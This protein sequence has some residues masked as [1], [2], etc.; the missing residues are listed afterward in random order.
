MRLRTFTTSRKRLL[1]AAAVAASLT[2]TSLPAAASP[3]PAHTAATRTVTAQAQPA[4]RPVDQDAAYFVSVAE[5]TARLAAGKVDSADLIAQIQALSHSQNLS[6]A[7]VRILIAQLREATGTVAQ[8]VTAYNADQAAKAAARKAAAEKA[9]RAAAAARA[10]QAAAAA[11]AQAQ[12]A[13]QNSPRQAP[14]PAPASVGTPVI[15]SGGSPQAIAQQMMSSR[16]GW[17]SDQFQCLDALWNRESGWRVNA[18]N[19]SGAYGIPQ[20]LPGSKMGPGWQ[21]NA[22]VQ[23]AWGLGYIQSRYGTPCG[24]WAHSQSTGWY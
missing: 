10:A 11:K 23:I 1:I 6:P 3:G 13:R 20:A 4:Q 17:G 5:S 7:V 15:V 9:A 24:A 19:S 2:F 18:A 22:A 16:Y 8:Q 14:S 21:N 12:Q